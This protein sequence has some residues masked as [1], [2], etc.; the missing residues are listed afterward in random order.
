MIRGLFAAIKVWIKRLSAIPKAS[1]LIELTL[2]G[3]NKTRSA[4]LLKAM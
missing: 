3:A 1:L 4:S 2:A